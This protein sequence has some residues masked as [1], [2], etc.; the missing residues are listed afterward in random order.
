MG[1]A[2]F[3]ILFGAVGLVV[4]VPVARMAWQAMARRRVNADADWADRMQQLRG[5]LEDLRFGQTADAFAWSGERAEIRAGACWFAFHDDQDSARQLRALWLMVATPGAM[6]KRD[7]RLRYKEELRVE[8]VGFAGRAT[9]L[10]G[11]GTRPGFQAELGSPQAMLGDPDVDDVAHFMGDPG[12]LLA[13]MSARR[14]RAVVRLAHA[15]SAQAEL[16]EVAGGDEL[17]SRHALLV[18]RTSVGTLIYGEVL[19]PTPNVDAVEKVIRGLVELVR[20][21]DADETPVAQAWLA[22]VRHDPCAQV[23]QR[24]LALLRQCCADPDQDGHQQFVA[25][26]GAALVDADP[27][28]RFMATDL[29]TGERARPVLKGLACDPNVNADLRRQALRKCLGPARSA[30]AQA[31]REDMHL[32][33]AALRAPVLRDMASEYVNRA[34]DQALLRELWDRSAT[35][36]DTWCLGLVGT[37]KRGPLPAN[38]E[39]RLIALLDRPNFK[40]CVSAAHWLGEVGTALAIEPLLSHLGEA[41]YDEVARAAVREIRTRLGP[42]EAGRVSLAAPEETAGALSL[43]SDRGALSK[44]EE[45]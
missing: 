18:Q 13:A 11:L 37:L 36:D 14:R 23:R 17:C 6:K 45:S 15:L 21:I 29:T 8:P 44:P 28:L 34:A 9:S 19:T 41:E 33:D 4:A 20:E 16:G 12:R 10:E 42:M 5:R 32:L 3:I 7:S 40:L 25:A 24:C 2:L 26:A 31:L 27:G 38:V 30:W 39:P 1:M 35:E 22:N 43:T